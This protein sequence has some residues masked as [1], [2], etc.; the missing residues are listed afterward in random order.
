MLLGEQGVAKI[1]RSI[2]AVGND[3]QL[4]CFESSCSSVLEFF[5][6]SFKRI[7]WQPCNG[8]KAVVVQPCD[9]SGIWACRDKAITSVFINALCASS[10]VLSLVSEVASSLAVDN[11]VKTRSLISAAAF[12]V[13]VIANI[14][15]GFF[16]V[17]KSDRYRCI[18]I[19]VFPEPAGAHKQKL[20]LGSIAIKRELESGDVITLPS[21]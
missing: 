2:A 7:R 8:F 20:C 12:R 9:V 21:R 10:R 15:L 18:S 4:V 19:S 5:A 17:P 13:K 14:L 1:D 16:V 3:V 6:D 11:A